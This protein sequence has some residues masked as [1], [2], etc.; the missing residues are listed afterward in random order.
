MRRFDKKNNMKKANLLA[1][2]RYLESKD[3]DEI[4]INKG[5]WS[6]EDAEVDI[7][8]ENNTV[9]IEDIGT[10]KL[11]FSEDEYGKSVKVF[12]DGEETDLSGFMFDDG[13]WYIK[14]FD[15][16]RTSKNPYVAVAKLAFNLY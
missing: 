12:L 6:G 4:K 9:T 3:L 7:D 14:A 8:E 16:N 15:M 5:D 1:E 11:V 10:F 2:Q 13:V